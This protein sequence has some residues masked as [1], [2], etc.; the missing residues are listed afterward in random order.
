[1]ARL[2]E[3]IS[4]PSMRNFGWLPS[5]EVFDRF[6][7]VNLKYTWID[8]GYDYLGSQRKSYLK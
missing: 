5:N 2:R 1:L 4:E 3:F 6:L 8:K 7:I